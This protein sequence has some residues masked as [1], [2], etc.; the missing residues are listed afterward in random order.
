[1]M[2]LKKNPKN[3]MKNMTNMPID[4]INDFLKMIHF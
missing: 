1:M 3:G 2:N 4:E